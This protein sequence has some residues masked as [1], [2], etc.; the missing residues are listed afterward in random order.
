MAGRPRLR[1]RGNKRK[2]KETFFFLPSLTLCYYSRQAEPTMRPIFL[3]ATLLTLNAAQPE[4]PVH[5]LGR[6][7]PLTGP[8]SAPA[9]NIARRHLGSLA[10]D[11]GLSRNDL[12]AVYLTKQYRTEHNGVTH[13]VFRQ[14]FLGADVLNA[15]WVVNVDA[16]GRILNAGGTLVPAPGNRSMPD[17]H[18]RSPLSDPQS[19]R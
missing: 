16:D 7:E 1:V 12:D 3:F 11:L 5:F 19:R 14:R 15:E 9:E 10:A 2:K 8:S 6:A 13:L 18:A 17:P 4:A